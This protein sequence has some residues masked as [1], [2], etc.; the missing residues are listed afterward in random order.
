MLKPS[1]NER[2][3]QQMYLFIEEK[4]VLQP[5]GFSEYEA[6]PLTSRWHLFIT[7]NVHGEV[8]S[9]LFFFSL[10]LFLKLINFS[11]VFSEFLCFT[12]NR[13]QRQKTIE[14]FLRKS[15]KR[16]MCVS[17]S[18]VGCCPRFRVRTDFINR[19]LPCKKDLRMYFIRKYIQRRY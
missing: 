18:S 17:M 6:H 11:S 3:L 14:E 2:I 15:E 16:N 1:N 13:I 12:P 10:F 7:K 9:V 8:Y 4:E 5:Q 19:R